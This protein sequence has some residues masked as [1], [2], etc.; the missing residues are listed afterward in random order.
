MVLSS[1]CALFSTRRSVASRFLGAGL[2]G[3]DAVDGEQAEVAEQ[4]L[5]V[6]A[7][8]RGVVD[9]ALG[10]GRRGVRGG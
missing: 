10:A 9:D 4:G 7:A 5:V 2:G 6:H 1:M 3:G 8:E